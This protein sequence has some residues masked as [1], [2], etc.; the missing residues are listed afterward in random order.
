MA[1]K[2]TRVLLIRH[3][4]NDYVKTHRLAGW[5]PD[6]HLND[7]GRLQA[8][9]VAERL[10]PEPI[11]A[12]Y[13]S[14][15][16]RTVETAEAIAL[17]HQLPVV[18][19]EGIGETHI[20]EWTGLLVED[21]TKTDL[22]KVIQGAPSRARFPGGESFAEIQ[23]RMVA[24]LDALVANHPEQT[25]VVVSHSD[26]IKLAV[27]FYIG[28]PLDLFQRL[29]I[30]PASITELEFNSMMPRLIR[31]DDCAHLPP[32]PKAE[33]PQEDGE[34]SVVVEPVATEVE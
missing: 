12:V 30:Q 23:G 18:T 1:E 14:P 25:I 5:T 3:G 15:L 7:H 2:P 28:Q 17:R 16:D 10:A 4:M 13:S 22:W 11:A 29:V 32:E 33:E 26:P 21:L 6:V 27:A 8:E 24:A 34:P 31:C 9:A 19:V 20:G